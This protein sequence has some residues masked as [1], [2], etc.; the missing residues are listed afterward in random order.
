MTRACALKRPIAASTW[1][2][3]AVLALGTPTPA[4]AT[5]DKA[6][7]ESADQRT[8]DHWTLGAGALVRPKFQGSGEYEIE[9]VPLV[10]V[11][12]G[13]FFARV[14]EGIGLNVIKTPS[15]TAGVSANWMPGYD[16]DDVARG[17]EDVDS[18]LGA[19]LFVSG[20]FKGI[21]AT[22][23]AT[24]AV[25]EADRGLLVNAGVAYPIKATE[26]LTIT[27]S[28]GTSWANEKYMNGYFGVESSEA[29]A[30]GL[31]QYEPSS[32]FKD[33]SF[34]VSASY[35]ITDS[36]GAVGSVGVT[37]LLG[38]ASDSPFVDEQTQPTAL[39]GLTYTF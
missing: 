7:T 26:R 10:D 28:L 36:I 22:L 31:R 13:P 29:A 34:R 33:I 20:Q 17:M 6:K 2:T 32:G 12:Y 24:Q 21:V 18:A 23:S 19:R 9:P 16:G 5:S 4:M 3:L 8:A 37:Q 14:G 11:K 38:E 15:F 25:T 35:R 30:S 27:P 1:F 39:I